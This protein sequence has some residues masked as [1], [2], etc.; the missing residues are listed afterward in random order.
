MK[1]L[2]TIILKN[3]LP[4]LFLCCGIAVHANTDAEEFARM[5]AAADSL[6]SIGRTDSAIIVVEQAMKEARKSG[7]PSWI[8]GTHS[9]LGVFL[10]SSGKINEAL[11]HYDEAMKIA[12]TKA[13][14]D[15]ADEDALEEVAALYVNLATLHLDMAHK[16]E[17]AQYAMT[18]AEWTDKCADKEFKAQIYGALGQVLTSA[19]NPGKALEFQTLAYKYAL[20]TGNNESAIR[21]A[22]YT[23]LACDRLNRA[24]ETEKWRR[25]CTDLLPRIQSTMARLVYFQVE[26]SICMRHDKHRRAIAWFDS[27]LNLDGI[28]NLPFV[29][30][31]CYN[32]MHQAYA[33]LGEHRLAYETL[34][35]SNELRD[36]LYEQQKA[37]SLRELTVKYDAKEKELALAQSES[38]RANTRFWLAVVLSALLAIGIVFTLYAMRQ[39][40]R[41]HESEME[42]AELRQDTE[43]QLTTRYIEGLENERSR[44]ARELHDGVCNDLMA[45][46]MRLADEQPASPSLA[47]LDTCREQVRRISHELLPPEFSYATIDEV[48]KYYI[49]KLGQSKKDVNCTYSSGPDGTD[50]SEIP[51]FISLEIYRIVQEAAGN[52]IKHS[53]ASAVNV[54]LNRNGKSVELTVGDN[55]QA[56]QAQGGGIGRRTMKQRAD[57]AGG[58]ITIE[59]NSKGTTVIFTLDLK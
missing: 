33:S 23:M 35:K 37:E 41:R 22:A 42:F 30:F 19:G 44:M 57:A 47:L 7:N 24:D 3:I 58:K 1:Q 36:S 46:Q 51:D 28:E 21:A 38:A 9:S 11:Q 5:R 55:G 34:L 2:Y 25:K 31:D 6:H 48:L 17:A 45:I 8:L 13:F 15:N 50:W 54:C 32:N 56:R 20:E 59:N 39:R 52:A 12:T 4:C 53:G 10:R 26:C 14:R 29:V 16:K 49:Y 27:I 18:C 40:R 43:H